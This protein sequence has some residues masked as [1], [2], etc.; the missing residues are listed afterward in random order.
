MA[1]AR[2]GPLDDRLTPLRDAIDR[3]DAQLVDLLNERARLASEVGRLKGEVDALVL[4]TEREAEVVRKVAAASRDRWPRRQAVQRLPRDQRRSAARWERPLTVAFLGLAGTF[5]FRRRRCIASSAPARTA[6]RAQ[7]S[8]R[9]SARRKASRCRH[10]AAGDFFRRRGQP[11]A[12][13]AA[14]HAAEAAGRAAHG[15]RQSSDA[16]RFDGRHAVHLQRTRRRWRSAAGWLAQHHPDIERRA[17][18]SNAEGARPAGEDPDVAGAG[19]S[20]ARTIGS[21][22]V[23]AHIQDDPNNRTRFAVVSGRGRR[24]R[25]RPGATR[26]LLIL[27]VPNRAGAV[28]HML[29]PLSRHG[30]SMTRFESRPARVGTWEYYF[31]VDVEGH[32]DEPASPPRW[33]SCSAPA[34]STRAW[35][36]T[37]QSVEGKEW[38]WQVRRT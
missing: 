38:R 11:H 35:G 14:C 17:V 13:P 7:R 29:E 8:T 2:G 9:C 6:C 23:A 24:L 26:S 28:F 19:E 27:S 32:Q 36:R 22:V 37:R 12:R 34:R 16:Q 30:V 3:V 20:V 1:D 4:R 5:P 31:Y 25:C 15:Q 18:A 10:R 33:A 21:Q